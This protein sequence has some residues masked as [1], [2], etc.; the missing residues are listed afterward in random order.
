MK[1]KLLVVILMLLVL[2]SFGVL[3]GNKSKP[4]VIIPKTYMSVTVLPTK[5]IIPTVTQILPTQTTIPT[6]LQPK[7]I[8]TKIIPKTSTIICNDGYVW[9][10]TVRKGA[11]HGHKG[12][13]K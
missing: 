7:A 8:P 4:P 5:T 2:C 3:S 13:R 6:V 10:S 1:N 12:I 9:P 11:C